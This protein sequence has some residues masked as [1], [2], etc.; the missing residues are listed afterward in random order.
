MA[1]SCEV[2]FDEGQLCAGYIVFYWDKSDH[3]FVGDAEIVDQTEILSRKVDMGKCRLGMWIMRDN[4]TTK[5]SA[6]AEYRPIP[7]TRAGLFSGTITP[8]RRFDN[9]QENNLHGICV[10]IIRTILPKLIRRKRR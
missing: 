3:W 10:H 1:W 7:P 8:N 6:E 4:E 2:P 5:D 9:N